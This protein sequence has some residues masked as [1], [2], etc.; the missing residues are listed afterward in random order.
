[1]VFIQKVY[2]PFR[3]FV[4]VELASLEQLS[5]RVKGLDP[6]G[7]VEGTI[8]GNQIIV[9]D[10]SNPE[11]P[12]IGTI[13]PDGRVI[14]WTQE[15]TE[16]ITAGR[17]DVDECPPTAAADPCAS[18]PGTTCYNTDPGFSCNCNIGPDGTKV[19]VI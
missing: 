14:T 15:G 5:I 4:R 18:Q 9:P 2:Y 13:S 3:G 17:A 8:N 10:P 7:P 16:I 19:R 6:S 11:F 12:K 1:M